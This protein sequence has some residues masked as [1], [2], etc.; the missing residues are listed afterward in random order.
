MFKM[1][2]LEQWF[3]LSDSEV[4]MQSG[5]RIDFL[6]FPVLSLAD[7]VSEATGSGSADPDAG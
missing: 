5:M 4:E 2:L 6:C 3:N 7:P 1:L